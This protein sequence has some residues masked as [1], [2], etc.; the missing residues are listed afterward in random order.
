VKA[1]VYQKY[2]P[3]E[4]LQFKEI[5][6]PVPRDNEIL[7]KVHA[8][9]V[10]SGTLFIRKGAHPDSKLYTFGLRLMLGLRKPKRSI[11]GFEVAGEVESVGKEVSQFKKG[12]LVFGTTTWLDNGAYAEYVCLPEKWKQGVV[13]L[14]PSNISFEQ[15]AA[16]PIGG[17]TAMFI[18]QKANIQKHQKVLIYGA[19]GSVGTFAVQL[20]VNSGAKVT[21]VCSGSNIDM[22][23]SL[24]ASHVIDYTQEDFTKNGQKYDVIFDCVTKISKSMC[25]YSFNKGGRYLTVKSPTKELIENLLNLKELAEE[26]KLIPVIDKIYPL[27]QTADAHAYAD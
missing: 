15:A 16:I 23:R 9:S 3:P 6:I 22:V 19:S 8:S 21:G 25:K 4:V 27:E 10:T 11:L 24:G 13:A 18:L 7:V 20:A 12:D 14:K 5:D 1:V 26:G 17:M 2:G